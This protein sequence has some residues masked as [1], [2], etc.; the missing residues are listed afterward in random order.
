MIGRDHDLVWR[1][2]SRSTGHEDNCVEMAATQDSIRV[3]DSK[4]P[5]A[6]QLVVNHD[7]W[8]AFIANR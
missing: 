3:R 5:H 6:A 4:N 2:S 8:R 1:K 7:A